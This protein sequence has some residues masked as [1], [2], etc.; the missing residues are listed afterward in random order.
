[1]LMYVCMYVCFLR[2][3]LKSMFVLNFLIHVTLRLLEL[4]EF[5]GNTF[6]Y[7]CAC[8]VITVKLHAT[9]IPYS[10]LCSHINS[11]SIVKVTFKRIYINSSLVM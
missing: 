3:R 5:H 4:Y 7:S 1:M 11:A 10:C 8:L 9:N 6:S 2:I